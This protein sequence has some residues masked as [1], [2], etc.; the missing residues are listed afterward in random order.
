[1]CFSSNKQ[2]CYVYVVWAGCD[3]VVSTDIPFLLLAGL[4]NIY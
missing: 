4:L 2:A 3:D 1:M